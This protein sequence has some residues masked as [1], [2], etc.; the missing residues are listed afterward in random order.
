MPVCSN[1]CEHALDDIDSTGKYLVFAQK[2]HN[3]TRIKCMHNT[4]KCL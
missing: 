2:N 1:L 3:S 4:V